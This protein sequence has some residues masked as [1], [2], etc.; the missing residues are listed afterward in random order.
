MLSRS[1]GVNVPANAMLIWD[2]ELTAVLPT[3]IVSVGRVRSVMVTVLVPFGSNPK[4]WITRLAKLVLASAG[5]VVGVRTGTTVATAALAE[6]TP[7]IVATALSTSPPVNV[8]AIVT[9]IR[10]DELTVVL[11]TVTV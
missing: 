6:L 5:V 11:L 4:P 1:P 9:V 8:P 7:S 10:H 2:A 3:L